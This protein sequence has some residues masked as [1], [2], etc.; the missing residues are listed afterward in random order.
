MLVWMQPLAP[1][2]AVLAAWHAHNPP[3]GVSLWMQQARNFRNPASRPAFAFCTDR[4]AALPILSDTPPDLMQLLEDTPAP[5]RPSGGK[6][7]AESIAPDGDE[8]VNSGSARR[9]LWGKQAIRVNLD[10]P[11]SNLWPVPSAQEMPL[12]PQ[13]DFGLPLEAI[14]GPEETPVDAVEPSD[15]QMEVASTKL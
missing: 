15:E 2:A 5:G 14:G 9:R 7:T 3:S 11:L 12:E 13:D 10:T 8:Q 4:R 6:R 1:T